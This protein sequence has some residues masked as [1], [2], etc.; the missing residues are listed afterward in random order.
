MIREENYRNLTDHLPVVLTLRT[1]G[2]GIPGPPL[3][4]GTLRIIAALPNPAGD[5]TQFEEV[6]LANGGATA[7]PL[8]GWRITNAARQQD[9]T[10]TVQDGTV[11]PGEKI[12]VVRKGR[13]MSLRN[14][15]DSV[16]LLNPAGETIDTRAYGEAPSGKLFLFE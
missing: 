10:L 6:H 15:G 8:T 7:V 2:S 11:A 13:P 12:V 16:V 1:T 9:W 14:G 4:G 5:D 3:A